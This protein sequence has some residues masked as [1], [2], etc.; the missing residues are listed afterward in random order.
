VSVCIYK[1]RINRGVLP[2]RPPILLQE[3]ICDLLRRYLQC[4]C[5]DVQVVCLKLLVIIQ[6]V[7]LI[8]PFCFMVYSD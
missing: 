8:F 6:S 5:P 1:S 2:S 3:E 7:I 4:N